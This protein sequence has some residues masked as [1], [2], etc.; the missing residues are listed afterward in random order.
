MTTEKKK[1]KANIQPCV[2]KPRKPI[3]TYT[4]SGSKWQIKTKLSRDE[5]GRKVAE[6]GDKI[7]LN[8][9]IQVFKASTDI[10]A[11]AA[12]LKAGDTTVLNAHPGISGDLTVLPKSVN[13]VMNGIQMSNDAYARFNSLPEDIKALFDND[14]TKFYESVVNNKV[15]DILAVYKASLTNQEIKEEVTSEK[16]EDN[17]G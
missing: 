5:Q 8:A 12:R 3:E 6:P 15:D 13:D 10:V 7:D 17:N 16:G 1:Q 9:Q 4:P 2:L 11:I 14:P